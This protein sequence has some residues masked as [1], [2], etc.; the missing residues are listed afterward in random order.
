[1]PWR[2]HCRGASLT[3][4]ALF[5]NAVLECTQYL[6][7][8][9]VRTRGTRERKNPGASERMQGCSSTPDQQVLP[10]HRGVA[11]EGQKLLA[12]IL[13]AAPEAPWKALLDVMGTERFGAAYP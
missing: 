3:P 6:S 1:M 4:C 9:F 10:P 7:T 12:Y 5:T 2:H 11:H 8:T 13:D